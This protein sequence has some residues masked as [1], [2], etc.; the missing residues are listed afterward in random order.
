MFLNKQFFLFIM[1]LEF[2]SESLD[3][4]GSPVHGEPYEGFFKEQC[5][6]PRH[7][8]ELADFHS[9]IGTRK[10]VTNKEYQKI[11]RSVGG[12]LLPIFPVFAA[13]EVLYIQNE[14]KGIELTI[15]NPWHM[16]IG[17][18]DDPTKKVSIIDLS[19]C[20][21]LV[22]AG[23]LS[24]E[25]MK[26][27]LDALARANI[28]NW[29]GYVV[30]VSTSGTCQTIV[31]PEDFKTA[32]AKFFDYTAFLPKAIED[33]YG[34]LS[35]KYVNAFLKTL[36][37]LYKELSEIF[38]QSFEQFSDPQTI[39]ARLRKAKLIDDN[40]KPMPNCEGKIQALF[41]APYEKWLNK[42]EQELKSAGLIDAEEL[43]AA[44]INAYCSTNNLVVHA[45]KEQNYRHHILMETITARTR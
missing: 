33:V 22:K 23:E 27:S 21:E 14:G 9:E 12:L 43:L 20:K 19:D 25:V 1:K 4:S 8:R 38:M 17:Q 37:K 29:L 24:S 28:P 11:D 15:G 31:L 2:K 3:C 34:K 10:I 13:E 40:N 41:E 5:F 39:Q 16:R 30:A 6:S 36:P 35:E 32:E 18:T 7:H 42:Y 45:P 26:P 44:R